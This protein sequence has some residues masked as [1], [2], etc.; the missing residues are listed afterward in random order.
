MVS[1]CMGVTNTLL[2]QLVHLSYRIWPSK[3]KQLIEA[4][5]AIMTENQFEMV[6]LD[7]RPATPTLLRCTD[8]ISEGVLYTFSASSR[9]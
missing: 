2:S 6:R 3:A 8:Y 9:V 7:L 4:Y 1:C 5:E